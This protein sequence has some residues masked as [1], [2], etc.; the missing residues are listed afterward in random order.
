MYVLPSQLTLHMLEGAVK[1]LLTSLIPPTPVRIR[2]WFE[3]QGIVVDLT[4]EL[5]V[6]LQIL[7]STGQFL[8]GSADAIFPGEY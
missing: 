4:S 6:A 1:G 5:R 2:D 3:R 7:P 8:K